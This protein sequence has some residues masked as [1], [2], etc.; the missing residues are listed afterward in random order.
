MR[1]SW[2]AFVA[3]VNGHSCTGGGTAPV[4][5]C[6]MACCQIVSARRGSEKR[7]RRV[8]SSL[9]GQDS[10]LEVACMLMY[11]YKH[12]AGVAANGVVERAVENDSSIALAGEQEGLRALARD[13][14]GTFNAEDARALLSVEVA[15]YAVDDL[16]RA[17][18]AG[19]PVGGVGP[20]EAQRWVEDSGERPDRDNGA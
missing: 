7:T 5:S 20:D 12:E 11:V 2:S 19:S 6:I 8:D 13:I 1:R 3:R 9:Q 10:L 17:R 18:I 15:R 16:L 14:L 4:V